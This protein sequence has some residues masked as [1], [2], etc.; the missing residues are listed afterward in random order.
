MAKYTFAYRGGGGMPETPEE[1]ER[2]MAAWTAWFG[3]LGSAVV[4]GG[5]PFGPSATVASGGGVTDGAPSGLTGYSIVTAQ[6]LAA[7][8][9]MAKGCPIFDA[10]G[11]VD[12][13]ECIDM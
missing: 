1:G 12:V 7:A 5:A 11:H 6:S 8:A 3:E 10:G 13:Y 9:E 2:L 4:D